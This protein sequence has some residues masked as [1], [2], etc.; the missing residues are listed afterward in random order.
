MDMDA[1]VQNTWRMPLKR[2]HALTCHHA[3]RFGE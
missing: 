1:G 2:H 3:R